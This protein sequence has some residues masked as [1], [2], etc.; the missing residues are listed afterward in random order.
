MLLRSLHLHALQYLLKMHYHAYYLFEID[1]IVWR[2]IPHKASAHEHPI[3]CNGGADERLPL[4]V[5]I[6][7]GDTDNLAFEKSVFSDETQTAMPFT[8]HCHLTLV[9]LIAKRQ[10][11]IIT[12]YWHI[13]KSLYSHLFTIWSSHPDLR[14]AQRTRRSS[15]HRNYYHWKETYLWQLSP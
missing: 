1:C 8:A 3:Y 12:L 9:K 6:F 2:L 5:C 15:P 10:L 7:A 4:R 11:S 13:I 14:H